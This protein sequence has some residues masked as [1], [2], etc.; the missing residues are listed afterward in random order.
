MAGFDVAKARETYAIPAGY[1]PVAAIALGY[2]GNPQTASE[3]LQQREAAP[4]SRK[5]LEQFVFTGEWSQ[6]SPIVQ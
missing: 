3:R 6:T 2:L 1:D 5:A 4:R